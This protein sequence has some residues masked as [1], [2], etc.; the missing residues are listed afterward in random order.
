MKK[1]IV[2]ALVLLLVT[3]LILTF[4]GGGHF[5]GE[6]EYLF[7]HNIA[8]Q[9]RMVYWK[10]AYAVYGEERD[11]SR[12]QERLL[13]DGLMPELTGY[14]HYTCHVLYQPDGE[15]AKIQMDWMT[16]LEGGNTKWLEVMILADRTQ[17]VAAWNRAF[18]P[19]W[20]QTTTTDID[21][22]TVLGSG[23]PQPNDQPAGETYWNDLV[24]EKN[25]LR[26]QINCIADDTLDG[27]MT[28]LD[29]FIHRELDFAALSMEKGDILTSE[30]LLENPDAFSGCIPDTNGTAFAIDWDTYYRLRNGEPEWIHLFLDGGT[31]NDVYW[32]INP[33]TSEIEPDG[34]VGDLDR[35]SLMELSKDPEFRRRELCLQQGPWCIE[36]SWLEDEFSEDEIWTLIES[37]PVME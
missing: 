29:F 18:I 28:L 5:T 8:D 10:D 34:R 15:V 9:G 30:Q 26:Y 13:D 3:A 6:P 4:L 36:I 14:E 22:V 35:E 16:I 33:M 25:G 32:I 19:A 27:M 21:G 2:P 1:R 11:F 24:F 7:R 20:Y 37:L 12:H 17:D 31:L 23:T